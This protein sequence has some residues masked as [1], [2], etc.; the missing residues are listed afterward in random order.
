MDTIRYST[1]IDIGS[2][3]AKGALFDGERLFTEIIPQMEPER[4]R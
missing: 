3:C 1:G 4:V 2:T